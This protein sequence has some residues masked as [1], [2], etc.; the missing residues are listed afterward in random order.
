MAND[1]TEFVVEPSLFA[2]EGVKP[3]GSEVPRQELR[4]SILNGVVDAPA[5]ATD[6]QTVEI[7][8]RVP[9]NY[10]Y[11]LAEVHLAISG[12][13]AFGWASSAFAT[14]DDGS[15]AS[16]RTYVAPM[17]GV[18]NGFTWN[19]VGGS[20]KTRKAWD[21]PCLLKGTVIP[22]PGSIDTG[23]NVHAGNASGS[24]SLIS[25]GFYA[26][27]LMYDIE[28]AHHFAVNTPTPVR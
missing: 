25:L 8:C 14:M 28:Q 3:V 9:R 4:F 24:A 5:M 13:D 15:A 23:L 26:R 17:E 11:V 22:N 18:S 7:I 10:A 2:Y 21:W 16:D 12:Q 6:T 20:A 27:I 19:L 1:H